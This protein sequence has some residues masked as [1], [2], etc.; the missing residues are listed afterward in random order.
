MSTVFHQ[1][2]SLF[3]VTSMSSS[4][5][6]TLVSDDDDETK[7]YTFHSTGL[8]D[9]VKG[10]FIKYLCKL[11]KDRE[12]PTKVSFTL[13]NNPHFMALVLD[14]DGTVEMHNVISEF[15]EVITELCRRLAQSQPQ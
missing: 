3:N 11:Y 10:D 8:K 13:I 4:L 7:V 14:N 15:K 5:K 1:A 2:V 6:T 9:K 12:F